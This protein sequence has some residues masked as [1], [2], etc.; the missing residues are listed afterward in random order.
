MLADIYAHLCFFDEMFKFYLLFFFRKNHD[1]QC[2][3]EISFLIRVDVLFSSMNYSVLEAT[4]SF[5]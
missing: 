5:Y 2:F 4:G 1:C 3:D